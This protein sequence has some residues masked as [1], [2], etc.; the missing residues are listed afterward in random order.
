MGDLVVDVVNLKL[1]LCLST[2]PWRRVGKW[3]HN[4]TNS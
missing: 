2:T 1:Y 4:S 3:R